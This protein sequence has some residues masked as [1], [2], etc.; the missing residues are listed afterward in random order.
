MGLAMMGANFTL[1]NESAS[2]I[3]PISSFVNNLTANLDGI[4]CD[5]M[6]LEGDACASLS[7]GL[8][9]PGYLGTI[10]FWVSN[11]T[12]PMTYNVTVPDGLLDEIDD[13]VLDWT[14]LFKS[15]PE[16]LEKA[17]PMLN[18]GA[19]ISLPLVGEVLDAGADVVGTI[20]SSLIIEL[21]D[22]ADQ[23]KGLNTTKEVVDTVQTEIFKLIGPDGADLLRHANGDG[24]ATKEDITVTC[25]N[26][27]GIC[28][29]SAN[30]TEIDDIQVTF[31]IGQNLSDAQ[32]PFD[33]GLPGLPLS[34]R[35]NVNVTANVTWQLLVD[36]GLSRSEGPYIV[37]SGANHTGAELQLTASVGLREMGSNCSADSDL[38]SD[39]TGLETG[40]SRTRYLPGDLGFLP[41]TLRDGAHADGSTSSPDNDPSRLS[42]NTS[43]DV[44]SVNGT[45]LTLAQLVAS[46]GELKLEVTAD[47]DINMRFRTKLQEGQEKGFPSVLGT[48]HLSGN[49][50]GGDASALEI[51]FDNLYLNCGEFIDKFLVPVVMHIKGVTS[52]LQPVVNTIR[53][54]LPVLT[55][56]AELM[57][58]KPVT[59]LSLLQ[60]SSGADLTMVYEMIAFINFVNNL[61]VGNQTL[62]L[63]LGRNETDKK[64]PG[65]FTVKAEQAQEGPVTPDKAGGRLIDTSQAAWETT[66]ETGVGWTPGG[67]SFPFLDNTGQ[68]YALLM[69]QDVVLVRCDMGTMSAWAS[70][71]RTYGPIFVGPVPIFIG[72]G[73]SIEVDGRFAIGYDTTGLRKAAIMGGNPTETTGTYLFDGIYIDDTD[74]NGSDVPEISLIG[75]VSASASVEFAN[76]S[77]GVEGGIQLTVD[78]NLKDPNCDGKLR[79]DE[80]YDRLAQPIC[81]F[82]VS[83]R[84]EAFLD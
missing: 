56:L 33:I 17:A 15:L 55:Q 64:K 34:A 11:I 21:A 22:L 5:C 23:L 35:E 37:T 25:R 32:T 12:D 69:G 49:W 52:P 54:P 39:M 27:T 78:M 47:A 79:I 40:Y 19:D 62:W 42:L 13:T 67:L 46:M 83:G 36:F 3:L 10:D 20:N 31:Y 9:N 2:D 70:V 43:L 41:V 58:E 53:A 60:A 4:G 26:E 44:G 14:L 76:V 18:G 73:G 65:S 24:N 30:V 84:I 50:N 45:R 48:F 82:D 28:G 71:T 77:G 57:G 63:A 66:K 16:L 72:I 1:R 61:P 75:T 80:V 6:S 8:D 29:D 81:M 59:M 74:G 38:P 7:V 51:R 68:I